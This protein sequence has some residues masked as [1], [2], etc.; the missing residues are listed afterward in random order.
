MPVCVPIKDM[1]DT[2]KF[3]ELVGLRAPGVG[4]GDIR[5]PTGTGSRRRVL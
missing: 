5:R 4:D 1:R 3:A 2:A